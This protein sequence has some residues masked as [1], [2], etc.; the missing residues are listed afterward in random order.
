MR[1]GKGEKRKIR[2]RMEEENQKITVEE[3]KGKV[4]T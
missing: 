3:I 4:K 1:V 2:K